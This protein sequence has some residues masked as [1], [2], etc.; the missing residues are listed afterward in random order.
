M[1]SLYDR[2]FIAEIDI[3]TT[4]HAIFAT[5]TLR[6]AP[7]DLRD[8]K[9]SCIWRKAA[10]LAVARGQ[11]TLAVYAFATN[12]APGRRSRPAAVVRDNRTVTLT[13]A[14][15]E[16]RVFASKRCCSI[17]NCA[18]PSISKGRPLWRITYLLLGDRCLQPS[19]TILDRF[20]AEHP[21][22]EIKLSTGERPMRWKR[23][24]LAKRIWRL[25]VTGNLA[26]RSGVFDAGES[27]GGAI[28]PALPCPVRNQVSVEKPDCLQCR[29]S[30]P[31]RDRYAAALNCVPT[32]QNQQPDDLRHGWRA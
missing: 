18:T 12:T 31:I 4:S 5:S 17:S 22:V 2:K 15:E 28:A 10:I 24:S 1:N 30:W 3:F 16:L 6:A 13:E 8:L 27:G 11:C 20:R 29:L 19:S 21:S 7:V 26:G 23:W 14:G 25:R 32:Q 9:T